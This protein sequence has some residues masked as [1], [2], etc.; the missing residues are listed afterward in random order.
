MSHYGYKH[1]FLDVS[2]PEF[3][4]QQRPH[5]TCSIYSSPLG[6]WHWKECD[7]GHLR[8]SP[9]VLVVGLNIIVYKRLDAAAGHATPHFICLVTVCSRISTASLSNNLT[10][11]LCEL[12]FIFLA[13]VC[14]QT[15]A[16]P[17]AKSLTARRISL[18]LYGHPTP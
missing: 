16:A 1:I 18:R 9:L 11:R 7:S 6:D 12:H 17:L 13:V 4:A 14:S 3:G 10:L 5:R 8:C 2:M 15:S